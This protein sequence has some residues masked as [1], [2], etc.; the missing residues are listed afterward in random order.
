MLRTIGVDLSVPYLVTIV[1]DST[2]NRVDNNKV[3]GA[4]IGVKMANSTSKKLTKSKSKNL[5][6]SFLATFQTSLQSS[7]LCFLTSKTKLAFTKLR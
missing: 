7:G 6:I 3:I 1:E 2:I 5:V 4:K